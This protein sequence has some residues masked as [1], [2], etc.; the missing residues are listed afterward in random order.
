MSLEPKYR[1]GDYLVDHVD[2]DDVSRWPVDPPGLDPEPIGPI[3][4]V[5][6]ALP[7]LLVL[8]VVGYCFYQIGFAMGAYD[9]AREI[10]A[11]YSCEANK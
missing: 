5:E 9:V 8:V 11:S 4:F 3:S 10:D 2:D 7:R 6:W 1:R